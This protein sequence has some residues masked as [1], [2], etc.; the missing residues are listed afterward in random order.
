MNSLGTLK[1][2]NL[3][4]S[5]DTIASFFR[6]EALSRDATARAVCRRHTV[7]LACSENAHE[8]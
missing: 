1:G 4:D 8:L 6:L 5:F 2:Y 7:Q 3:K